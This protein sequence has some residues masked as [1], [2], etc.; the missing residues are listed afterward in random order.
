M[1]YGKE[2]AYTSGFPVFGLFSRSK[3]TE[4]RAEI[5]VAGL[6]SAFYEFSGITYAWMQSPAVILASLSVHDGTDNLI[7][8]DRRLA[9]TCPILRSY[10][11]CIEGGILTGE[12]ERPE[13]DEVVP[14]DVAKA[15]GD[16]WV[17]HHDVERERDLLIQVATDGELLILA[18]GDIIPADAYEPV[19]AG[20]D[21]RP[22]VTGYKIGQ[23]S[24]VRRTGFHY[25]GDRPAGHVRAMGW[26]HPAMPYAAG[27]QNIRVAAAHGLGA[28]AK[29][30]STV[31]NSHPDRITA[32]T[33]S[34]SGVVQDDQP[35]N[36]AGHVDSITRAGVGSVPLL[37]RGE[38]VKRIEAG[39]DAVATAYESVLEREAASALNVPLSELRSDYSSGSFS[40]LK[41]AY[42]D[43][44]AEYRRRRI[45]WTRNYRRPLWRTITSSAYADGKLPSMSPEIMEAVKRP[46]W[47]GPSRESPQPEKEMALLPALVREGILAPADAA[48]KLEK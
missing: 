42:T 48:A 29:I 33:G 4:T 27:L 35:N 23:A 25:L 46:T 44:M 22:R 36:A 41:M 6:Y 37:Q 45:W 11:S 40:N 2:N 1:V 39:P 20:P 32:G 47:P 38:A 12:E 24:T 31:E 3:P 21:W 15:A 28:L 43:A 14:E 19:T 16:L 7:L 8:E 10:L 26:I 13:F 18:N 34:R 9:R 30:I 5:D 17:R